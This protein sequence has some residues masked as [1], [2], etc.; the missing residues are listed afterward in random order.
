L[1]PHGRSPMHHPFTE[2]PAPPSPPV[3]KV[4]GDDTGQLQHRHLPTKRYSYIRAPPATK[5]VYACRPKAM[6]QLT[7]QKLERKVGK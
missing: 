7:N 5:K 3:R 2:C 1:N 6:L 4:D